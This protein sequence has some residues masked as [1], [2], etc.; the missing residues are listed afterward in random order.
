MI[1]DL[2]DVTN[3]LFEETWS[4]GVAFRYLILIAVGITII[5]LCIDESE[6]ETY[7]WGKFP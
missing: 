2:I 4:L 7:N 5:P 3:G 1:K 6:G